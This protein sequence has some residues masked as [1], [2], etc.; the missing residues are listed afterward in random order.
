M[1]KCLIMVVRC[2]IKLVAFQG[3][4]VKMRTE[5]DIALQ[6]LALGNRKGRKLRNW[7]IL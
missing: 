1:L 2:V 7:R 4:E 6:S 5:H 3:F